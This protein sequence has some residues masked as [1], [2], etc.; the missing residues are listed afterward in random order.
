VTKRTL[1]PKI[2]P[3]EYREILKSVNLQSI[4]MEACTMKIRREKLGSNM[5]ADLQHKTS[6]TIEKGSLA[7]VTCD[8]EIVATKTTKK[9][10]AIKIQATYRVV[11]ES[12][13][14]FSEEF[15]DIYTDLNLQMNTWPYFRE[16]VQS[17]VQRAGLPPLTLPFLRN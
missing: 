2:S 3:G 12:E 8:Y 10:F 4:E 9:E 5:K 15:M 1:K 13:E 16:F 17:M 6:Y 14:A 11:L 7:E